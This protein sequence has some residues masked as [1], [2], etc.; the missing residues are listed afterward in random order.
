MEKSQLK[1]TRG[2]LY[3]VML[4]VLFG[5]IGNSIAYPILAPLFLHPMHGQIVPSNWDVAWRSFWMGVTLMTYPLGQF[6]GL[7][8]LGALS[9]HHG[10][11]KVLIISTALM[12]VFYLATAL[13]LTYNLLWLLMLSRFLTGCSEGNLSIARAIVVDNKQLNKHKSLGLISSMT[14]IGYVIGPLLGGGLADKS[15]VS[16]FNFA[17]PFYVATAISLVIVILVFIYLRESLVRHDDSSVSLLQQFNI[18]H[19]LSVLCQNKQLKF[20]LITA[21]IAS[22]S[23]DTFYEFYPAYM[24]GLWHATSMKIAWYTVILS[25]AIALGCSWSH[26]LTRYITSKQSII[27][28]MPVIMLGLMCLLFLPPEWIVMGLFI[29]IGFGIAITITNYTLQVSEA[30]ASNIQGEVLGMMWGLRML[31][32]GLI[33]ITG[34]LLIMLSYRLPI[35]IA[36][37]IALTGWIVYCGYRRH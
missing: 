33:S 28:A 1:S 21:S 30:G 26:A 19:R 7:P 9:D 23:C 12:T 35:A 17:L 18:V 37:L 11:K 15:L 29:V 4:I 8:V 10:R 31:L 14:A 5:F 2:Q 27:L 3:V 25:V 22:L 24:T 6:I 34:G 32:D 16:W 36:A 20:L 13:S